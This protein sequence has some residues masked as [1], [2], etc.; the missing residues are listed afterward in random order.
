MS[1]IMK[2]AF[3]AYAKTKT[4]ISC[5]VTMQLITAVTVQLISTFVFCYLNLKFQASNYLLWLYSPVYVGPGR[6]PRRQV[7]L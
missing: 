1:R 6:E 3:F 7:F 4:Q 5:V 2:K